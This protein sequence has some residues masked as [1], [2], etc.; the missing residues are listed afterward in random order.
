MLKLT[1]LLDQCKGWLPRDDFAGASAVTERDA[2][3]TL[4]RNL[5]KHENAWISPKVEEAHRKYF[6][7]ICMQLGID[8]TIAT[9]F[10]TLGSVPDLYGFLVEHLETG[11]TFKP[12]QPGE[13]A[14][15]PTYVAMPET[16]LF[17]D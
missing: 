8:K 16:L 15:E 14:P 2:L 12:V 9:G 1:Q 6:L 11:A 17:K 4:C 5:A 7:D 3:L 10:N 13:Q